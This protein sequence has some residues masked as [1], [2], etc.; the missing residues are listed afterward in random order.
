V[1]NS[2]LWRLRTGATWR[3]IP[4]WQAV[5]TR[6]D[7]RTVNYRAGVVLAPLMLWLKS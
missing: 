4:Q 2:I 3:G 5:A 6:Y 1:I 7:K